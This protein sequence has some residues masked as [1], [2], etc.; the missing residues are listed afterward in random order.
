MFISKSVFQ[1][2]QAIMIAVLAGILFTLLAGVFFSPL[3][4]GVTVGVATLLYA[5]PAVTL[6]I[7]ITVPTICAVLMFLMITR[8]LYRSLKRSNENAVFRFYHDK[9]VFPETYRIKVLPYCDIE[10]IEYS[11]V[12]PVDEDR[13][14]GNLF[15]RVKNSRKRLQIMNIENGEQILRTVRGIQ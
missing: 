9:I 14:L 7:I 4:G 3:I 2:K 6:P 1:K 12:K 15:I 8:F 13:Q 5:E 10:S 11:P